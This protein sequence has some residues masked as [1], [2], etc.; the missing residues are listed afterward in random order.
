MCGIVGILGRS[1]VSGRI[2]D[3]L[4][5]L[6]YRGYDSAGMALMDAGRIDVRRSVGKLKALKATPILIGR[7]MLHWSI[8]G[9]SRITRRSGQS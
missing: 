5:R 9:L 7:R 6:E 8:T 1:D 3:G 4:S 2:L